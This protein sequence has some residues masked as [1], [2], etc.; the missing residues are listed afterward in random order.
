MNLHKL[1]PSKEDLLIIDE[2]HVY[3]FSRE[4]DSTI[5]S[6]LEMSLNPHIGFNFEQF[7]QSSNKIFTDAREII[8][9]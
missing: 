3:Q 1:T 4:G 5:I 8:G 7:G 2:P 9:G 6:E